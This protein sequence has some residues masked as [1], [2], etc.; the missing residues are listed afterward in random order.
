MKCSGSLPDDYSEDALNE[1]AIQSAKSFNTR[2]G[3]SGQSARTD[4]GPRT[5]PELYSEDRWD[6][7]AELR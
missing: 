7:I 6:W 1:F 2:C 5:V 4:V 3:Q